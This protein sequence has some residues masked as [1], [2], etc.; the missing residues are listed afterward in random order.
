M[1]V[2]IIKETERTLDY[3][4]ISRNNAILR[5]KLKIPHNTITEAISFAACEVATILDADAIISSTESGNTARQVSKNRPKSIIIG[6]SPNKHVVRQLMLTWGVIPLK[7][8]S[9][10]NIN[11]MI[12]EAIDVSLRAGL[13]KKGSRVVVTAGVMVNKPGSTNLINVREIE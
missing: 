4:M 9:S 5:N 8:V 13:I 6:T 2:R 3:D 10:K 11:S 1:M 7:T 12:E